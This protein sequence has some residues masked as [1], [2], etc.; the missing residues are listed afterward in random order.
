MAIKRI[1][2]WAY[3]LHLLELKMLYFVVNGIV[4][5]RETD[6]YSALI[7]D[8]FML[9]I[10]SRALEQLVTFKQANVRYW[11][12]SFKQLDLLVSILSKD[13]MHLNVDAL[14]VKWPVMYHFF[15]DQLMQCLWKFFMP[16]RIKRSR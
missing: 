12:A 7:D 6:E 8:I 5:S 1:M 11:Y 14:Q 16:N 9:G 2:D 10:R 4:Y 3:D 13:L 15:C